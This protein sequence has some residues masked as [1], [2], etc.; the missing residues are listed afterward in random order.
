[1]RTAVIIPAYN[2]EHS[3]KDVILDI[4]KM[5]P[6]AEIIVVNDGSSDQTSSRARKTGVKVIDHTLN[7]GYG[8]AL[9]TGARS[10][11]ADILVFFDADTQHDPHDIGR[12]IAEI[13]ECD[14]VVGARTKESY[15]QPHRRPGKFLLNFLANLVLDQKIPDINSGLRAVKRDVFLTYAHLLP[16]NFSLTTTIT[17]AFIKAGRIVKYI[18]ITVNKRTGTSTVNPLKDG[19]KTLLLM[20]RIIILFKPLSVFLPMATVLFCLGAGNGL[21]ELIYRDNQGIGQVT[22]LF[23]ISSL[24]IFFFGLLADQVS[25][26]RR[27]KHE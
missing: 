4:K 16:T 12:L 3:I 11:G 19:L 8:S 20:L 21:Y 7:I 15:T 5:Y 22:L 2:E 23:L 27:E 26:M 25:S 9:K 17:F 14:M 1:M 18:P 6:E 13:N 10:T 24:I